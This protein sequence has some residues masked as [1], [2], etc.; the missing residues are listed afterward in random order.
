MANEA[1]RTLSDDYV[2][3][4][5]IY[6][7][8]GDDAG[9]AR[10]VTVNELKYRYAQE[11][12]HLVDKYAAYGPADRIIEMLAKFVDA[13]VNYFIMAPIM[14]P[15]NRCAHLER[16]ASEVLPELE[17]MEPGRVT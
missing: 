6:V 14:P 16:L 1:G 11:F 2:F 17:K 9:S 13:G 7:C 12:D 3:A 4:I 10:E 5:F 8:I 15:N